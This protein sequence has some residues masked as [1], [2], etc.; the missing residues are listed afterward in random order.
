LPPGRY[1]V[2]A[3]GP[4]PSTDVDLV[5]NDARGDIFHTS[6]NLLLTNLSSNYPDPL[7]PIPQPRVAP[8]ESEVY[9]PVYFPTT[10]DRRGALP[11]DL[12]AGSEFGGVD[13]TVQRL[14]THRIRGTIVDAATGEV[15]REQQTQILRSNNPPTYR[16]DE[17]LPFSPDNYPVHG[18]LD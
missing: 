8:Q 1:F 7:V 18:F 9:V 14:Q 12:Q 16:V 5:V 6:A 15:L 10:T 2:G 11:I 17:T 13:I 3:T 4:D